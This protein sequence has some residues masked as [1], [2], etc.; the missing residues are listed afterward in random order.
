MILGVLINSLLQGRCAVIS[1]KLFC[2]R[3]D[4]F[5]KWARAVT[6]LQ[7]FERGAYSPDTGF[8]VRKTIRFYHN[9]PSD[10]TGCLFL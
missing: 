10:D 8:F 3:F 5:I 1:Q 4:R 7:T 6:A 9:D 2:F